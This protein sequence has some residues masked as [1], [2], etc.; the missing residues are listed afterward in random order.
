MSIDSA[1]SVLSEY[2]KTVELIEKTAQKQ[3]EEVI[4]DSTK[5]EEFKFKLNQKSKGKAPVR[6]NSGNHKFVM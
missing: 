3:L 2:T 1:I 4:K 6:I 5:V